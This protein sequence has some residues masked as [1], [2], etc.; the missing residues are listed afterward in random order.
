MFLQSVAQWRF[1]EPVVE[2]KFAKSNKI[3]IIQSDTG[4]W[5]CLGILGNIGNGVQT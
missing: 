5:T 3:S 2:S 1:D 4:Q